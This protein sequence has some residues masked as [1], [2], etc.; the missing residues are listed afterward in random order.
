MKSK[1]EILEQQ[2]NA[3]GNKITEYIGKDGY[4]WQMILNAME[5]YAQQQVNV[6]STSQDKALNL[7]GVSGSATPKYDCDECMLYPCIYQTIGKEFNDRKL[8]YN[9][10]GD[11]VVKKPL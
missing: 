4:V 2:E 11:K 1:S 7:A 10:C 6:A 8:K 5:E 3:Q 9:L